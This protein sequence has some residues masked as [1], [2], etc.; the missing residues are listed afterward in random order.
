MLE[1]RIFACQQINISDPDARMVQRKVR[2]KPR[3]CTTKELAGT[4]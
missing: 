2:D 1:G 4:W 3:S